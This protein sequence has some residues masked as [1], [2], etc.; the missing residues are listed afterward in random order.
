MEILDEITITEEDKN[1]SIRKNVKVLR[2]ASWALIAGNIILFIIRDNT[3][4]PSIAYGIGG[5]LGVA[6]FFYLAGGILGLIIATIPYKGLS[7]KKRYW[8]AFYLG[9]IVISTLGILASLARL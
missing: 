5:M 2:A 3:N 8:R 6:A 1:N 9:T 4:W 7:F